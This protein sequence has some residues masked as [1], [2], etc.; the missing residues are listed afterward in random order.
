MKKKWNKMRQEN[1]KDGAPAQNA[2]GADAVDITNVS[3]EY[4]S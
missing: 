3:L 1:K 4:Y 2:A